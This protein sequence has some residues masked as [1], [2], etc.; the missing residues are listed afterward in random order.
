MIVFKQISKNDSTV[1]YNFSAVGLDG[2]IS[3]NRNSLNV[4]YQKIGGHYSNNSKEKNRILSI[5]KH[6]I[7][8]SNFPER[9]IYA[10]H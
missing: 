9:Y 5:A 6:K 7:A 10:T 4:T 3:I 1:C 2:A 8:E